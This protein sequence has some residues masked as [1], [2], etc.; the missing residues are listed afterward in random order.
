MPT[1]TSAARQSS[2]S[3]PAIASSSARSRR[4]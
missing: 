3:T 2:I 4:T 1:A